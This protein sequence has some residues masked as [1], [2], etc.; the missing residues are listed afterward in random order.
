MGLCRLQ[1]ARL[2]SGEGESQV[3]DH[4]LLQDPLVEDDYFVSI[5]QI[6]PVVFQES[7]DG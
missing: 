6:A 5:S 3:C 2:V 4:L 1:F 7:E